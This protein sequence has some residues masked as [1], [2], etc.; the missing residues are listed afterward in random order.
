MVLKRFL[1]KEMDLALWEV[2]QAIATTT[3]YEGLRLTECLDLKLKQIIRSKEGYTI[4]HIRAKQRTEKMLTKLLVPEEGGY[5]KCLAIYLNKV[6]NK[7]S[8]FQG[9]VWYSA[10]QTDAL[11]SQFMGM[12]MVSKV[13]QDIAALF[14][15]SEP[16]KFTFHSFRR[17][18]AADAGETAEQLV[19]F[20]GWKNG[21]ICQEYIFSSRPAIFS[22][23]NRLAG[24]ENTAVE[25]TS[26]RQDEYLYAQLVEDPESYRKAGISLTSTSTIIRSAECCG[27]QHQAG[28]VCF[29]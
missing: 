17:T 22:M 6:N 1:T 12:H 3:I 2:R 8:S 15:V 26:L 5:A 18:R 19:H 27:D 11:I 20:F 14:N 24:P 21:S 10:R 9:R 29:A 7:L 16:T 23:A 25:L 28:C 4:T 13:A